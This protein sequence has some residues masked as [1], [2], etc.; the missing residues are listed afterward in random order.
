MNRQECWQILSA[1]RDRYGIDLHT[2]GWENKP[3]PGGAALAD[4]LVPRLAA[5]ALQFD[6]QS[7]VAYEMESTKKEF[8]PFV[9]SLDQ[10]GFDALRHSMLS[11]FDLVLVPRS[12]KWALVMS[13]ELEGMVLGPKQFVAAL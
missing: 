8:E 4:H 6:D 10:R 5:G 11:H 7:A 2:E 13:H 3:I 12:K 1:L 9:V